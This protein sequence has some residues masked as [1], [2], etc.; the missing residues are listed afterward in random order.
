MGGFLG[1]GLFGYRQFPES[2]DAHSRFEPRLHLVYSHL[3]L[4]QFSHDGLSIFI[5][6]S[7]V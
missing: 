2:A 4:C 6:I 7:N 1:T 3:V 5:R